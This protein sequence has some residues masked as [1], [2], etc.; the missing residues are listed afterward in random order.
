MFTVLFST[1]HM[2]CGKCYLCTLCY[3]LGD[4][5]LIVH[6][7]DLCIYH[8]L[9]GLTISLS[10]IPTEKQKV[11]VYCAD[12]N[13][14]GWHNRDCWLGNSAK[15][16]SKRLTVLRASEWK[17]LARFEKEE[18]IK[19]CEVICGARVGVMQRWALRFLDCAQ[20]AAKNLFWFP[21][22]IFIGLVQQRDK[23]SGCH[24]KMSN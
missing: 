18:I 24:K 6:L 3:V 22:K 1:L 21:S 13:T 16:A 5:F 20:I 15:R 14:L 12:S 23:F 8:W 17:N 19:R 9:F 11:H 7:D 4:M 2:Q 10:I